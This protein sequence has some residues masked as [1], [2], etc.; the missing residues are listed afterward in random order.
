MEVRA[1]ANMGTKG[2][3]QVATTT[4]DGAGN[5]ALGVNG[6][7]YLVDA[8]MSINAAGDFGDRWYDVAGPSGNGYIEAMADP[9]TLADADTVPGINIALEVNG[10]FD[11]TVSNGGLYAGPMVRTELK[12]ERRTNHVDFSKPSPHLGE[13]NFRGLVPGDYRVI[14]WDLDGI[15]E[16][17][18]NG[19][20]FTVYSNVVGAGPAI[21]LTPMAADPYEPNNSPTDTGS[22]LNGAV[23]RTSPPGTFTSNGALI[24]PGGYEVD[25]Y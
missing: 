16:T 12:A 17:Y 5:Y 18:V 20:P 23:F 1:W 6:G 14:A 15:Y 9:I 7:T 13:Y 8:R 25:L 19:G 4:S 3:Q 10:G 2:W 11:G 22:A 24:G 21:Y